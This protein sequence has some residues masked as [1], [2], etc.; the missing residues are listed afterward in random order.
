M[1]K[2]SIILA[3]CLAA[4][5]GKKPNAPTPVHTSCTCTIDD[6]T[7][8]FA[9]HPLAD[10]ILAISEFQNDKDQEATHRLV[11]LTDKLLNPIEEMHLADANTSEARNENGEMD[12]REQ[13]VYSYCDAFRSAVGSLYKRFPVGGTLQHSECFATVAGE[14]EYLANSTASQRTLIVFSDLQ[15]NSDAFS[16]YTQDGLK[17]LQTHPQKVAKL[18]QSRRSLPKNLTGVTVYFVYMPLTRDQDQRF[19]EM[20]SIYKS[21][22]KERGARVVVQAQNTNYQP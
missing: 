11:L 8:S 4:S 15:E 14:L 19:N 5:C 12:N 9:L 21:L 1:K 10:P 13:L 2:L 6:R 22:L 7:D 18:L 20:V 3:L 16:C 17:L